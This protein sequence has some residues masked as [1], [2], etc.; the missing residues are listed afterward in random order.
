MKRRRHSHA[1]EL[2]S[3]GASITVVS[4]R[5]GHA[6]PSITLGIYSH[7]LPVDNQAAAKLWNDSMADVIETVS[8]AQTRDGNLPLENPC[9][10]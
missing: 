1:S 3:K 9:Q 4:E 8:E 10:R 2:L 6:N 5:L 7:A